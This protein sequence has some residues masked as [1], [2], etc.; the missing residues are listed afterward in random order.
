M[1]TSLCDSSDDFSTLAQEKV[2]SITLPS[3]HGCGAL[4]SLHDPMDIETL[5]NELAV[6]ITGKHEHRNRQLSTL[7]V[8]IEADV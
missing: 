2:L 7:I 3:F 4:I 5:A 8:N 6:V 1:V